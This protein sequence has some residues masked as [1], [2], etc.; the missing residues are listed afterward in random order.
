MQDTHNLYF[1]LL[2]V[3]TALNEL[4][5]CA[6][7]ITV[8]STTRSLQESLEAVSKAILSFYGQER[9]A[10]TPASKDAFTR[11]CICFADDLLPFVQKCIHV[12]YPPN[13]V[14][15]L[16]GVGVQ[17]LQKEGI[18]YIVREKVVVTIKHLLPEKIEP[19]IEKT[20]DEE[21]SK[22]KTDVSS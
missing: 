11:F 6:P 18:S 21:E 16:V 8:T 7:I 17:N 1:F 22:E 9:Q 14:A 4:R 20:E 10:F 13:V 5:V 3:L 2:G 19:N 15:S 12:V